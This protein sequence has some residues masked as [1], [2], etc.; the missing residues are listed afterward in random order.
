MSKPSQPTT[1]KLSKSTNEL[2]CHA[3]HLDSMTHCQHMTDVQG[4]Y[5]ASDGTAVESSL[6]N[7][8][9]SFIH[10]LTLKTDHNIIITTTTNEMQ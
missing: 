2:S 5:L 8:T 6:G 3:D 10:L 7:S 1:L 9:C 4:K